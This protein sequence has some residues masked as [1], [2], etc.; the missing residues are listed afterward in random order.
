MA[1]KIKKSE[2]EW[3]KQLTPLQFEVTR[4]NAT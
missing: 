3:R 2:E 1:D 4:H